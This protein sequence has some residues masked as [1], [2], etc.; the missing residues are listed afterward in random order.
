[1]GAALK[2]EVLNKKAAINCLYQVGNDLYVDACNLHVQD[3]TGDSLSS[4]MVPNGLGNLIVG[5]NEEGPGGSEKTGSHN[6]IVGPYHTYTNQSG[7][8]TGKS[9]K[10][11]GLGA[12]VTG[13]KNNKA[14][15][16]WSTVSGGSSN[17][18]SGENSSVSGGYG[19]KASGPRSSV[20]GGLSNTAS[21]D[22]SSVTGGF[23]NEAS[24]AACSVSGGAGNIASGYMSSVSGGLQNVAEGQ[25]ETLP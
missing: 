20:S 24:G 15:A 25:Y 6:V 10:I 21:V 14:S 5:Y 16:H 22:V 9:N 17:W 12:A 19:N 1:M 13:G 8:V 18:A 4:D 3:G 7:L 11:T 2:A 23:N